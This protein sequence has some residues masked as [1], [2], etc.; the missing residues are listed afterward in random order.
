VNE[1]TDKVETETRVEDIRNI[2]EELKCTAERAM[3][4][5][6]VPQNNRSMYL[7]KL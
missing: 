2:M 7:S 6:K 4:M 3:D 5:L 1:N